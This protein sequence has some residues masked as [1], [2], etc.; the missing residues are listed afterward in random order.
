MKVDIEKLKAIAL[1]HG[2]PAVEEILVEL[3]FPLLEEAVAS[4]SNKIDDAILPL[5]EPA[6][7]SAV[8]SWLENLQ[9][10]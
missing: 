6:M 1:K 4:S 9:K 2:V 7:K 5:I 3:A 8:I 10:A